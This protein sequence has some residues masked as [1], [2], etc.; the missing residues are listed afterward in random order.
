MTEIIRGGDIIKKLLYISVIPR[1]QLFWPQLEFGNT[2]ALRG[3]NLQSNVI[4][5]GTALVKTYTG[6]SVSM[7][8][9]F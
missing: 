1:C 5:E 2:F 6:A 3:R 8:G 7:H 9:Y 4:V